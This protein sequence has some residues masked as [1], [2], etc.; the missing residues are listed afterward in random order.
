MDTQTK[1]KRWINFKSQNDPNIIWTSSVQRAKVLFPISYSSYF[2]KN[3]GKKQKQKL[4]DVPFKKCR[5]LLLH[6]MNSPPISSSCFLTT[7]L[8]LPSCTV[9]KLQISHAC[10]LLGGPN[11]GDQ[12]WA[13]NRSNRSQI[14]HIR[15][16]SVEHQNTLKSDLKNSRIICPIWA[17]LAHFGLGHP[18]SKMKN[19]YIK[20][21]R[22]WAVKFWHKSG[23]IGDTWL[24][25]SRTLFD[26]F[27]A[28]FDS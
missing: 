24:D 5:E 19:V 2:S 25:K 28:H 7:L 13:L 20:H 10:N 11:Q 23:Q 21:P 6:F 14:G 8:I 27:P 12:I 4:V 1:K 9:L 22:R 16:F 3:D 17:H 26:Q 15:D 18:W